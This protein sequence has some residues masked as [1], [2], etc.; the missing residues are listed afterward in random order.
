M[1]DRAPEPNPFVIVNPKSANGAT[2]ARFLERLE[3]FREALP[4]MTYA[5]TEGAQHAVELAKR[6]V[7]NGAGLVAACG[8]DGTLNE[9]VWG[10]VDSG[11]SREVT[12]AVVPSG[13]G[14][15]FRKSIGLG[16]GF[17]DALRC[18]RSGVVR[19]VDAGMLRFEDGDG[20][21]VQRPFANIASFGISGLVDHYVN[22]STKRL[23]G[24]VSFFIGSVRGLLAW[25]NVQMRVVV[26]GSTF[27]E[28][29]TNLVTM[30]NGR[31]FGGGMQMAPQ[32]DLSDGLL[33]V[34]VFGDMSRATFAGMS[35]W[36]YSGNHLTRPLVKWTR[37]RVVEATVDGQA[38]VDLDGE[39]PGRAPIRAE[40]LPGALRL[41]V[42]K[43][44]MK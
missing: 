8:G 38:L 17:D 2:R 26:D 36:I 14:G 16:A 40:V 23:G 24:R 12:L 29:P 11:R 43:T 6:A 4:G 7:A 33:D 9:V 35:R 19:P 30:A 10:L 37:G 32:A 34:V 5:F 25:K 22:T 28:G 27:H 42:P 44:D 18:L 41:L 15:D 39:Q 31:F 1:N 21:P 20:R 3:R 13:T